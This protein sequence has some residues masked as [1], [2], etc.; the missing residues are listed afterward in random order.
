MNIDFDRLREIIEWTER[1]YLCTSRV[2]KRA[3]LDFC[4]NPDDTEKRY[5]AIAA[6]K[7]SIVWQGVWEALEAL[8]P[9]STTASGGEREG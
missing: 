3:A 7:E 1:E 4:R 2:A 9:Q 5:E 6:N 8:Y